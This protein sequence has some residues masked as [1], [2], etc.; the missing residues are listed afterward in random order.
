[1]EEASSDFTLNLAR[2]KKPTQNLVNP[3]HFIFYKQ[4][5]LIRA[6]KWRM[7]VYYNPSRYIYT[8]FLDK[9]PLGIL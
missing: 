8:F 5:G 7:E 1:M 6:F 2:D 3:F 4:V 9:F